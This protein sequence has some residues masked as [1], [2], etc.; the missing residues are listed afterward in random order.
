[1]NRREITLLVAGLIVGLFFGMVLV[2]SS[3]DL[4]ESLFGTS[5][6]KSDDSTSTTANKVELAYYLAEI[7]SVEEWL[8][9][10]YPDTTETVNDSVETLVGLISSTDFQADFVTAKDSGVMDSVL[11]PTYAAFIGADDLENVE[12]L[13]NSSV[14]LGWEEDP[15]SFDDIA[16]YVYVTVPAGEIDESEIPEAWEKLEK[17]KSSDLYWQLLDCYPI[18]E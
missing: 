15:Y 16:M 3:D 1:M 18:A 10:K 5:A 12:V 2:G 17:P 13:P 14:C 6:E 7:P 8:I 4:R 11:P 9:E